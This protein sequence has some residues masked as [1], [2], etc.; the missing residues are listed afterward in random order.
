MGKENLDPSE[1]KVEIFNQLNIMFWRA[2]KCVLYV[3]DNQS[4]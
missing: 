1:A 4:I 3:I 2:E